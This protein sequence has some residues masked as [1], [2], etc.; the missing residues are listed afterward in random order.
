[1]EQN[2]QFL[3]HVKVDVKFYEKFKL[4]TLNTNNTL[5]Q[6]ADACMNQY[7][8]SEEF[9]LSIN[10]YINSQQNNK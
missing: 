3:T 6:F 2:E 10:N 5:Q 7:L 4:D 1:M 9:K 8:T